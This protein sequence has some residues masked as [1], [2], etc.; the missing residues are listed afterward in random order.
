MNENYDRYNEENYSHRRRRKRAHKRKYP[1]QASHVRLVSY[2]GAHQS[3]VITVSPSPEK[4]GRPMDTINHLENT[5]HSVNLRVNQAM[6]GNN[7]T[8]TCLNVDTLL[9]AATLQNEHSKER[10]RDY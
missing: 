8:E 10:K 1:K 5:A 4:T 6:D 7:P 9:Y 2:G 3:N